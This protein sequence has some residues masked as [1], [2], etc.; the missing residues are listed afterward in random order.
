MGPNIET[1]TDAN[2]FLFGGHVLSPTKETLEARVQSLREG[3]N[4]DWIK[5]TVA[6]LPDYLHALPAKIPELSGAI[7]GGRQL[8]NFELWIRGGVEARKL[9][10][11]EELTNTV[12]G[13][14]L[15]ATQL[16]QYWRYLEIARHGKG[17]PYDGDLQADLVASQGQG[18][19]PVVLGFCVG[20]LGALAV[21]SSANRQDFERYGAAAVRLG[22]LV[23]A[24]V[25]A[26]EVWDKGLGKGQSVSY[27]TAWRG[28][29]QHAEMTRI[30]SAFYP[31]AY[32]SVLFDEARAT[33]TTS[34]RTA[35]SLAR[36]FRAA[37][38][39]VAEIGISGHIHTPGPDR[40]RHTR[41]LVELCREKSGL[42]FADASKLALPTYD[43]QAGGK[44]I[45]PDH[46]S[47]TE[48]VLESILMLQCNWYGTFSKIVA[49][50]TDTRIVSFGLDRCVPP[51]LLRRLGPRQKHFDDIEKSHP[52]PARSQT[53][54][55]VAAIPNLTM[56]QPQLQ[57]QQSEVVVLGRSPPATA[58]PIAN[59]PGKSVPLIHDS[60][61]AV[62]GMS[63]KVAGADDLDEFVDML[64]KGESQHKLIT[65]DKLQHDILHRD[66]DSKRKFYANFVRGSDA[67]DH[68]FF[69]RSP[70][71]SQA[72]DPQSRLCLEGAYQAVEQSGY[73]TEST[74]GDEARNKR[75]VGVFIGN[76]GVD[77]EQNIACNPATAFTATG[78]LRSFIHG[79]LSHYFGWTGPSSTI[80]TACSSSTVAIHTACR[81]LLSGECSAAL[82][83]GVNIITSM[84][85]MQN[86]AA[87][88]F[89]SPTGQCK[90]F[91]D[92]ADG[93]CRAEGV[94]FVF[95]KRLS[96]A[97]ADGNPI[98][99]TIPSTAVY[100]NS[101][102]TP[103]FVPNSSSLSL[104]FRDVMKAANVKASDV[105]LVEAHGTGTPVGDPAEYA[106]IRAVVGGPGREK[107]V[108]IGSVKG[109]VGHTEGASGVI[110]LVKV[111][112]MMRNSFIPAQASFKRL[113]HRIEVRPDDMME[114]ATSARPWPEKRKVAL[115]NNYG[116]CGSNASM[117]VVQP[118]TTLVPNKA[119]GLSKLPFW[120]TG[121]DW[122]SI[123]AYCAKLGSWLQRYP[124]GEEEVIL[125][126]I[127]FAMSRQSNRSLPNV[128][129]FSCSSVSELKEK[130]RQV[131]SSTEKNAISI[132]IT[133][134]KAAR[135]VILCFGG[136]IS[137]FIGLDRQL[138]EGVAVLCWH[139]NQCDSAIRSAGLEGIYPDI[140]SREPVKDTVKLQTML[141]AL[142]YSC[143][144]IWV[145]CG[146]KI[147]AVVGHSFGELTALCV[148]G[149]L[150]VKDA[151]T[152]VAGRARLV[153]DSWGADSGAMMAIDASHGVV[154]DLLL[155]TNRMSDSSAAIACHNGPNNF[156]IAGSTRSINTAV[157]VLAGNS[158]F[159]GIG[160]KRLNVT[161]AFHSALVDKIAS[162]LGKLGRSLTFN[163]PN[164]PVE[165]ATED[166]L[167]PQLDWTFVPS[168]MRKAVFFDHA[169]QRLA[170]KHP[171]A[172]FLEAGS[173]STVT[174]MAE[175]ALAQRSTPLDAHFQ[176]ISLTRKGAAN[177]LSDAT[178]ALWKRGL[179]VSFWPYHARQARE[180]AQ[181]LLP[182]YQFDKTG[183]HWL[184][185]KSPTDAIN[186]AAKA[187]IQA[188][189]LV[190]ATKDYSQQQHQ[191]Q[192]LRKLD[193][194]SFVAYQ[195][196]KRQKPRFKINSSSD[197]YNRFF[198]GHV[199]AQTAPICPAT[200][201]SDMAIEALFSLH[202]EWK[203]AGFSPVLRNLVSHS[204][205][206]ANP[207]RG[208]YMD[209]EAL[210][211]SQKQ[212]G[213][214]TFSVNAT[215]NDDVQT[216]VEARLQ[217]RTPTDADFIQEFAR[218][219]RL[220]SHRRCLALLALG[221]DGEQDDID[222]LRGRN[223]Y[224]ALG[225]VVDYPELYRGVRSVVGRG[226]ES[227]GIVHKRHQGQTWLDVPLSDSF[228]QI[229]G[230]F[231]NL[232]TELSV[233]EMYIATGCEALIRSPKAQNIID[234]KENGP[235]LYQVFAQHSKTSDKE[236]LTDVFVFDASSGT[237]T[238]AMLGIQY[239]R[240][241]KES[242]RKLLTR[243]TKD[244]SM[245]RTT[246]QPSTPVA[247][248]KS[249]DA[250]VAVLPSRNAASFTARDLKPPKK[251][252]GN[253]RNPSQQ[254]DITENV[255]ELVASVS[256]IEASEI[257]FDAEMTDLGIDSLM[258]MELA[259]EVGRV[260]KCAIDPTEQ[261]EA[262]TLRKFVICVANA[263]KRGTGADG[264]AE[265][266]GEG[267]ETN[268]NEESS[269]D[270]EG[271]MWSNSSSNDVKSTVSTPKSTESLLSSQGL[272]DSA[273]TIDSAQSKQ[274]NLTLPPSEILNAFGE[275]KMRSDELI[276]EHKLDTMHKTDIAGS[277]RLCTALIVEALEKLGMPLAAA[278]PGQELVRVAF[279]PQHHRLMD[280]IYNFLERVARLI[281]IETESGRLIR[282]H[283]AA[284]SKSSDAILHGLLGTQPSFTVPN[285]LTHYA[286][287]RLADVL[288]GAT[289]GIR[290]IFGT[291]QGREFVRA[292]YCD[293]AF[294]C[295]DYLMMRDVTSRLVN[296][297]ANM[298]PGETL[299]VLEMGAGTG[300]TT[301]IMA[302]F[303][304]T[305]DRPVE[306]TFTDISASMV[307]NA[308][309]TFGRRYS[310]M[311]FAV[312]DIEKSPAE[313]LKD[314]HIILASNAVH[315][316]HNLAVSLRNIRQALR[317]DGFVMLLEMT[318]AIPF[319]DVVFGL[320][321]GWWYF[322]DGR[323]HAV[324]PVAHWEREL[325]AAGF[326]YVNWTDGNL[327]ENA[328]Q[329]VIMALATGSSETEHL[330]KPLPRDAGTRETTQL[331][332][333][334]VKTRELEAEGFV[335]KYTQGWDKAELDA[336]RD[337]RTSGM[338]A[339]RAAVVVITGATGS[340]GAHLVQQFA[341]QDGVATVVCVNRQSGMPAVQRQQDAFSSRG[342]R[343][344]PGVHRKLRVLQTDTSKPQLGL[345][346]SEY[347]WLTQSATH[348]VHNAWPMSG[349]RTIQAFESQF[350]VLRNLLDLARSTAILS[351]SSGGPRVSFQLVSSI[352]VVGC[353][354]EARVL[355][356][357]VPMA[358]VLPGGYTE[359]K[360]ACERMLDET[361]RQY[362]QLFRSMVVRP[363]QIAGS[364]A[365]GY[366]NPLE[367][368]AFLV[369]SAQALRAWPDLDGTLQWL[370]VDKCARAMVELLKIGDEKAASDDAY[371]VYHIDN[372]VGQPW[373]EMSPVL[374]AALDIPPRS[375]IP[376]KAWVRRVRWSPLS[377]ETENPAA[378]VIDFLES[379][380]ERMSCGGLILDTQRAQQHSETMAHQGPVPA[381]VAR[382]YIASWKR[383]GFLS[384]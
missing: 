376:F 19:Q 203:A 354:G 208:V 321:E 29:R 232:M 12:V 162:G 353:A 56:Q 229:G 301:S 279:V 153:R 24:V 307:A 45:S 138:Y 284:P 380:F 242:M 224:R 251:R 101:N 351:R 183:R 70:R 48:M 280:C 102:L 235:S 384:P 257:T 269:S 7:S 228:S 356:Q 318:E 116:A 177:A 273:L 364:T 200:L 99:A 368:F 225:D 140:F 211:D 304:A 164:I 8:A 194:F 103:L 365:S 112:M 144:K 75:H 374:A 76:C 53:N 278:A 343:L 79:R 220:V 342:I 185:M 197:E 372:P 298:Q 221:Q 259:S 108:V 262:T 9:S 51:S 248:D 358:A 151:I 297:I 18:Q 210:D 147:A 113:N 111:I 323:K 332:R 22:M 139:L 105:S 39:V 348:I 327:P 326:G 270:D 20:L 293:Y 171:N 245:L 223:V 95:L 289:D 352:G 150:S 334:D 110:A 88:G 362:P 21:S 130:L 249:V 292:M 239:T 311:K 26:R 62:V 173:S 157:E 322:D 44:Q 189:G 371:P 60:N 272:T 158:R 281:D 255:R 231:V 207:S 55:I 133:P 369:K 168:H 42:Q 294:N 118:P 316:T 240:V 303:L 34:E 83:G 344:S 159:S 363:G 340:L 123:R 71:E 300:G 329:K 193:L 74:R 100:Q 277:N 61:I 80:D 244:T 81:S 85:W 180:Y 288:S 182:P 338:I 214:S 25:D 252:T 339:G 375:I 357:R 38:L 258:G 383:T 382:L 175:R 121:L 320:L 195:D 188:Q 167:G 230:M 17:L 309:Q 117:L 333:G 261:M 28:A 216:H 141:F 336:V 146:C 132:G 97:V 202:P 331:D 237:M 107:P 23:G 91:D 13:A 14:L 187:I 142:Q 265:R 30:I 128:L 106:S 227:A 64:R 350:Q 302:P 155:E 367:H 299:K 201:V 54:G 317:P 78:G 204:P 286:G 287:Q 190:L 120:I 148:A 341:K 152:L 291:P 73:F 46:G 260:F 166:S 11:D 94:A 209:F 172:I 134:V 52:I 355:E 266:N 33:V 349:T 238:E 4:A 361:L 50:K 145:D 310:F 263:L 219:E 37:S 218:L 360:W 72:I 233:G 222:V 63:I 373:K 127:S 243:L 226:N 325:R 366:W 98:L 66:T 275:V 67:F 40:K 125:A 178:V 308:R 346:A 154:Q 119:Y 41:A 379:H 137:N 328:F 69:K 156:T 315:A 199:I 250:A 246:I 313:E 377:A 5:K 109:H 282:T 241:A 115:I 149:V 319:V 205:I 169:I 84:V 290:V 57:P 254:K 296:R 47:M 129:V 136:Q 274:S 324:V 264:D 179:S 65:R 163:E 378:R 131:A 381:D 184:E 198:A 3:P 122:R 312:H 268:S 1:F 253:E 267:F 160:S 176:A 215:A 36:Q 213:M 92:A 191:G 68:K 236:Y 2:I 93:Y 96:D 337:K 196:K 89:T 170:K 161:N 16:D 143:S 192:D 59:A 256:G 335:A 104:L 370:P 217:F 27:A 32:I 305:L 6:G 271:A 90:P 330:P 114:I 212:W 165:H 31:E 206:C 82:C 77:Y 285:R 247:T 35:P 124:G 87:G 174:V 135:P 276:R 314:Q 10:S 345:P 359:A 43:N 181:L 86:L 283:V 126:D 15:V 234:G 58:E 295:M 186:R 49:N 306:Y 347:I